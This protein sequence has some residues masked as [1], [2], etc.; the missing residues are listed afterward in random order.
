M[1]DRY[2][3]T[4]V[5]SADDQFLDVSAA[6]CDISGYTKKELLKLSPETLTPEAI[7][8]ARRDIIESVFD[9]N[10]W[11][12]E[13]P[14]ITKDGHQIWLQMYVDP[15]KNRDGKVDRY[16]ATAVD[17]SEKK[18]IEKISE[19]DSLTG[20]ANRKKLDDVLYTEWARYLRYKKPFSI[21]LFDLD[22]FKQVNDEF[23][24]LEGDKVLIRVAESVQMHLRASDAFGRWGG[25]EFL[26]ILPETDLEHAAVVAE[27]L[28]L[29]V[30]QITGLASTSLS[31]SFGVACTGE[32]MERVETLIRLADEALYFAKENGR[33]RVELSD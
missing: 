31:A 32:H 5:L 24:H 30:S 2:I 9:G 16:R 15:L 10:S 33:N 19:T 3:I 18:L 7:H 6:F 4:A 28:R 14:Q 29:A 25:E 22:Y 11:Q 27:K 20:I 23:G 17:I 1:T 21:L 8:D 26:V 12:G 13:M